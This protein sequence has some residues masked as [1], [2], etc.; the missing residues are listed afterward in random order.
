MPKNTKKK[1]S[2]QSPKSE[3]TK[4]KK[5][6]IV[7]VGSNEAQEAEC[8]FSKLMHLKIVRYIVIFTLIVLA[9]PIILF[10]IWRPKPADHVN[11]GVTF[12]DI[13]SE[14][15]GLDWQDTYIKILDDLGVKHLRLVAYWK[16]IEPV[17]DQ[18]DF[19]RI[20]WQL[21]EAQERD[22][23]VILTVG[24]KV[25]RWPECF[26]PK[27]WHDMDNQ[28]M[29]RIEQYEFVERTV[30]ELKDYDNIKMW[31]VENEPFFPFGI[32]EPI[33]I[34]EVKD[35]VEIVRK[36]DDYNRPI[37]IQDSGEGGVW[38]MTYNIAD[39]LAISMYRRI[40]FDFWGAIFGKSIYF[41]YPLAHWTY[42][43]KAH[44]TRVP[45]DKILVTELQAE[46]WGPGLN[47]KLTQEQKDKTMSKRHFW[48]TLNYAQKSGIKD[49]Y[50][51]GAEWWL[52]EKE[53]N[54]N[55]FFWY[56]AKGLFAGSAEKQK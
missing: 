56:T 49:I 35:E 44:L 50:V 53:H 41:Q 40:W 6:R 8:L 18:Y 31:Q 27:W 21:D 39:Y 1:L 43:I 46:P 30:M 54:D 38:F 42:K 55:P 26:A 47:S 10:L 22:A 5:T 34:K 20:K 19:S 14:E 24:R 29:K 16:E 17:N 33:T 45:F 52:W 28:S 48:Q 25:P 11:W 37:V 7:C 51:W 36:A 9:F 15:L 2:K 32:C 4:N 3:K 12:S 13:Y 23:D